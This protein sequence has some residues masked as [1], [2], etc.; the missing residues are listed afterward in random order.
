[1]K[2]NDKCDIYKNDSVKRSP[3]ISLN[4]KVNFETKRRKILISL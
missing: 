2:E 1:M 4:F 3:H